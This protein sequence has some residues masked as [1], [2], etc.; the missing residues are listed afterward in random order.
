VGELIPPHLKIPETVHLK[1]PPLNSE[2]CST[3]SWFLTIFAWSC[4]LLG[5][6]VAAADSAT[7]NAETTSADSIEARLPNVIVIVA[8]DLG[9]GD[10]GCYGQSAIR[11]PHID[12]LASEGLRFTDHYSGSSVGVASRCSLLTGRHTGN[13]RIRG[14]GDGLLAE[15]DVTIAKVMKQA[16]YVTGAIGKW[17]VGHPPP[18]NDPIRNGF[19]S[20]YGYLD[21]WHANNHFPDFLWENGRRCTIKGNI[22][23]VSG[24]GGVAIKRTQYAHHLFTTKG[25]EFIEANKDRSFFLYLAFNLPHA[26]T[27][28]GDNG[29]EVPN[30][31]PYSNMPWPEAQR[32]QA[33]MITRLDHSVGRIIDLLKSLDLQQD[34]CVFFTSDNGPASEGG[35]DPIFFKSTRGLRGRKGLL[36]EGGIR[37]PLIV[38]WPGRATSER[39]TSHLSA[40]WD[41]MP[42]IFELA[43]ISD[44]RPIE[45][46]GLSYAPT[47]LDDLER[48]KA[49]PFLYWESHESG[50]TQ[51]VRFATWKAVAPFGARLE[52]YNLQTDPAEET[53]V[54]DVHP[55]VTQRVRELLETAHRSAEGYM[56][57]PFRAAE[58][59]E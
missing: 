21:R 9:Y 55:E 59:E 36:Y 8:D 53:N 49:H 32:N 29:M 11:T 28:A 51:A 48:Q 40:F 19:D 3:R 20:F 7:K 2:R 31:V 42:T 6:S 44:T 46:D 54:A 57:T 39:T 30:D 33:S 26:N 23:S 18:P 22:V 58:P 41:L 35:A 14:T 5:G 52:L 38:W 47:I 50:T 4:A 25:L 37:V 27:E 56:L 16:G 1:R 15:D 12:R 13:A 24:R 34:T 10:L 43:G 17:A 45:T